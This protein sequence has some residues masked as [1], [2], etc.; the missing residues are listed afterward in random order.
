MTAAPARLCQRDWIRQLATGAEA[1]FVPLGH[2]VRPPG[3]VIAPDDPSTLFATAGIQLWRSWVLAN[4]SASEAGRIGV[5]W[6][7]RMNS[8]DRI[9]K[10]NFLTGFCMLS[11]LTRG[12][13]PR[14][15]AISRWLTVLTEHWGLPLDRLGFVATGTGPLAPEDTASLDAL[16]RLGIKPDHVAVRPRKWVFPFKPDGPT[17]PELFVLVDHR[18]SVCG[19]GCGPL[20]ACGRY[21]HFWNLEFLDHRRLP[22]SQGSE[23]VPADEPY[24]DSAGSLEWAAAAVSGSTDVYAAALADIVELWRAEIAVKEAAQLLADHTRTLAL[25]LGSGVLPGPRRHGHVVRRLVRRALALLL[26]HDRSPSALGR[27]IRTVGDAYQY[28]PGFTPP[29]ADTEEIID[30]EAEALMAL[31]S[32]TRRRFERLLNGGKELSPVALFELHAVHGLP[33]ELVE[34]WVKQAGASVDNEQL[35]LLRKQDRATARG[36]YEG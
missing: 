29:R 2:V 36:R 17:G 8:L 24:L 27:A 11:I 6:C 18:G 15:Q 31:I 5:Q 35:G 20:C 10:T 9:G 26:R 22:A 23:A 16:G 13:Q 32:V 25:L 21:L 3:P 12:K 7:V 30:R 1:L 4:D 19:P 28:H 33:W 14:E 34:L